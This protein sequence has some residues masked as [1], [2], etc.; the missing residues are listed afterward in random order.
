MTI[1]KI[2]ESL[3][4]PKDIK[5]FKV[6]REQVPTWNKDHVLYVCEAN[7]EWKIGIVDIVMVIEKFADEF[8]VSISLGPD[9]RE[10]LSQTTFQ[11]YGS[12]EEVIEQLNKNISKYFREKAKN[13]GMFYEY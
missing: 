13:T 1:N 7:E 2:K 12:A 8:H 5:L 4:I 9:S 3:N 10:I 6:D 11:A